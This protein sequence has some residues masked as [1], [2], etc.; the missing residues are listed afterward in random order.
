M[1]KKLNDHDYFLDYI[2]KHY[3]QLKMKYLRFCTEKHYKFDE[4]V[5]SNTIL[6]C[7]DTIKK[8]GKLKNKTPHGIESYF[9]LAFRNNT[10]LEAISPRS[11]KRD[12]N[13]DNEQLNELYEEYSNNHNCSSNAKIANDLFTDFSVLYIM[14][15]VEDNFDSEHFYLYRIKTLCGM[16]FKQLEEKTK[17]KDSRKKFV[18]V[19]RWV[20]ENIK[21]EDIKKL[22]YEKYGDLI[23]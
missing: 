8:N 22:F 5:Y 16:T 14:S 20:K 10:F 7:Y 2:S 17:V 4:D 13:V 12:W 3:N 9:F 15:C 6:K 11:A 23:S 18:A 19:Q 21:K 1:K